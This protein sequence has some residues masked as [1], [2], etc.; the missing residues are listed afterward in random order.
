MIIKKN[1]LL[2]S[3]IG[4]FS[5]V[6]LHSMDNE[7]KVKEKTPKEEYQEAKKNY[8][9]KKADRDKEAQELQARVNSPRGYV[10]QEATKQ[11]VGLVV[12]R[13]D[14]GLSYITDELRKQWVG[15]SEAEILQ[16]EIEE[17]D[18]QLK[19]ESLKGQALNNEIATVTKQ[20]KDEE[21]VVLK[22]QELNHDIDAAEKI[23]S[24]L[25][26]TYN[27][28]AFKK[29]WTE[30]AA[31]AGIDL[32]EEKTPEDTNKTTPQK[33]KIGL[34]SKLATP[35]VFTAITAGQFADFLAGC[36]FAHITNLECF[37][38]TVIEA[39]SLGI[40]RLLIATTVAGISY[41]AYKKYKSY[42]TDEEDDWY[43][44][45]DDTE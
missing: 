17:L 5:T 3:V 16:K 38:G 28:P 40:N 34:L 26:G 41:V 44:N 24:R 30:L 11:T 37:K 35:F 32:P 15:L 7:P 2:L 10:E 1:L 6:A 25:P 19:T 23:G 8:W 18:R 20:T 39:H 13:L 21:Q 29:R 12:K 36:S 45:D 4:I 9:E 42:N 43:N 33:E 27:N 14:S 22:K 31:Q